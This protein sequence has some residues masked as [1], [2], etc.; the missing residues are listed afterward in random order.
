MKT[1]ML[2]MLM[3][4]AI[5]V[6]A[7]EIDSSSNDETEKSQ[8]KSHVTEMVSD[9]TLV[10][11]L[12]LSGEANVWFMVDD[13]NQIHVEGVEANDFLSEYHIRKSL[14]GAVMKVKDSLIGKTFSVVI[15]FVQSK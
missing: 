8:M 2:S 5:V 15:D 1:V 10:E 4:A 13:N 9:A 11:S 7:S 12:G 6:N 3:S 14:E